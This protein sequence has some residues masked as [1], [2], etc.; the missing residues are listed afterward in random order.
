M[1]PD[2]PI[3]VG[4]VVPRLF[5][6]ERTQPVVGFVEECFNHLRLEGQCADD[7]DRKFV[8]AGWPHL[9][10]LALIRQKGSGKDSVNLGISN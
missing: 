4:I 9:G 7:R 6:I 5:L 8:P 1:G 3:K 2:P 10:R